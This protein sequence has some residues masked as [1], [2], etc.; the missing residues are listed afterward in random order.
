MN[1]TSL[2]LCLFGA[3]L[4]TANIL[5]IQRPTCPSGGTEVAAADKDAP[6]TQTEVISTVKRKPPQA[7]KAAVS[8]AEAKPPDASAQAKPSQALKAAAKPSGPAPKD[9]VT[10]SVKQTAKTQEPNDEKPAVSPAQLAKSG[11]G[12]ARVEDALEEWADVS[13]AARVHNAPSVSAPTVRFYRVGT[14]LK[15]IGR[16]PGWIKVVDPS[17]SKEGWIYEKYLTPKEGPDQKQA[18]LPQ[19]SQRQAAADMPNNMNVSPPQPEP[20]ARSYRPRHGWRWYR[21]YRPPIGFAFRVYPNW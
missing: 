12:P 17:A 13:L 3:A 8:T 9:D 11:L 5:I 14:R 15:V 21:A 2:S 16:E 20:Y 19:Q 7:A 6:S 10:G 1:K 4:A 18:G